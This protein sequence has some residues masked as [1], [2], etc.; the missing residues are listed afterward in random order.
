MISGCAVRAL[1]HA[2]WFDD[3]SLITVCKYLVAGTTSIRVEGCEI[4]LYCFK[5]GEGSGKGGAGEGGVND[6][7][8]WEGMKYMVAVDL[9]GMSRFA[10]IVA[11]ICKGLC[12]SG[13]ADP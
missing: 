8:Q 12:D 7:A 6:A 3:E 4:Q 11:G 1:R 9:C 13:T 10:T 2:Q 5:V